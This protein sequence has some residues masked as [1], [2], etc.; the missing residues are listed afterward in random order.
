[1]RRC[2]EPLGF[3]QCL[4]AL[5]ARFQGGQGPRRCAC[6]RVGIGNPR[7][8]WSSQNAA[9]VWGQGKETQTVF[10]FASAKV[11]KAATH[12]RDERRPARQENQTELAMDFPGLQL[13]LNSL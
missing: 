3:G 8:R 9:R 2:F 12:Q 6:S 4:L 13:F 5:H 10:E 7:L 11:Q 1:M